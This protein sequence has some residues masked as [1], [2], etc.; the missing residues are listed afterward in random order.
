[1]KPKKRLQAT[2]KAQGDLSSREARALRMLGRPP[3]PEGGWEAAA[4]GG[5]RRQE[6]PHQ[7]E[8]EVPREAER[9]PVIKKLKVVADSV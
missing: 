9:L 4:S 2:S 6:E 5:A 3:T 7:D 8:D 1:M